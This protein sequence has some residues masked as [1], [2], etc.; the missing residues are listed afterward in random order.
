MKTK[1][2]LVFLIFLLPLFLAAQTDSLSTGERSLPVLNNHYF[3]PN[4]NFLSPFITTFFKTGIGGGVS[5][6]SIPVYVNDG[7][8]L[9]GRLEGENTYVTADVHVQVEA[10][11]WLAVWFRYQANAR[12]GSST[13]TI[14]AHGVTAVT[15]FEFGWMLRLWHNKKS[16]LS[17][18]ITINNATVSAVNLSNFIKDIIDNPDSINTSLSR[19]KNP[20]DGV[21]GVRYAYSFSDMIG[22]QAFINASYG[23]SLI[24]NNK[25]VWK[26]NT[27]ILGSFNFIHSHD[28]PVGLNLGYTIQKFSLFEGQQEDNIQSFMFKVAYTGRE[29]YNIGLEFMHVRTAAPLIEEEN[30]IEYLSTAFVMV[31]YF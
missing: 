11:E 16:Q 7:E 2:I 12:I 19:K 20:L 22:I 30:T 18:T 29:E 5:L 4:S 17:G 9:L 21:A 23:E 31:Y 10:K 27:G 24:K 3:T 8:V 6:N 14:L 26:F 25:N 1:A 28:V 13:P 15:G